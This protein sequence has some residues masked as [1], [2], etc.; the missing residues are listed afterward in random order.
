[1][2][3]LR[4][5]AVIPETPDLARQ[6]RISG[7]DETPVAERAEILAREERKAA[8]SSHRSCLPASIHR[9]DRLTRIFDDRH[10]SLAGNREERIHV[11]TQSIKMH[12]ND[13]SCARRQGGADGRGGE[14]VCFGVDI[15]EPRGRAQ[16]R[17]TSRRREKR[18]GTG[19]DL[20]ARADAERHHRHK[21]RVGSRRDADGVGDAK[22][23]GQLTL[24]R[25]DL[26]PLDEPLAV[27]DSNDRRQHLVA[28][29]P[30]L[31]L[32]VQQRHRSWSRHVVRRAQGLLR[33]RTTISGAPQ[34]ARSLRKSAPFPGPLP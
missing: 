9:P 2:V 7:R 18:V 1:M 5:R 19:D 21:E 25:G 6:R 28:D 17:D 8:G 31:S 34:T 20:V 4:L 14:I 23:I 12:R 30:V 29:W 32:Q 16:P 11:G 10:A 13:R 26:G 27:A 33:Q 15:H 3:V 22:R 24:E